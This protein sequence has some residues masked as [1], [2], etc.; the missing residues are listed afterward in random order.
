MPL[1]HFIDDLLRLQARYA[2][3]IWRLWEDDGIYIEFF[4]EEL[5][6]DCALSLQ[7]AGIPARHLAALPRVVHLPAGLVNTASLPGLV[8]AI[9]TFLK[10]SASLSRIKQDRNQT[11]IPSNL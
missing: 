3:L 1:D 8:G 10:E 5:A 7:R 9:H 6:L 11:I 4:L 2:S